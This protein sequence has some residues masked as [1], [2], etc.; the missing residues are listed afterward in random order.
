ME[1]KDFLNLTDDEKKIIIL[2]CIS[3]FLMKPEIDKIIEPELKNTP[4]IFQDLKDITKDL[5]SMFKKKM[6]SKPKF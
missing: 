2:G 1:Q 4:E 5:F 6:R 3:Y